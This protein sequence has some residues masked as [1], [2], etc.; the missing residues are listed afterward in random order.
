M[1]T[2]LLLMEDYRRTYTEAAREFRPRAA[3][4]YQ[5]LS[6]ALF[7]RGIFYGDAYLEAFREQGVGATQVVPTCVPL[8]RLWA[9]EHRLRFPPAVLSER[10]FRWAWTRRGK[11]TPLQTAL[12][13]IVEEQ[14][15]VTEPDVLWAF[16]GVP[17]RH[18]AIRRWRSHVRTSV[19]WWSCELVPDAAYGDFDLIVSSIGPLVDHFRQ[20]GLRAEHMPHAF[21]RRVLDRVRPSAQRIP[22]SVFVGNL[23]SD[24]AARIQFLDKLSRQVE[25]DFYGTGVEHLP[26]DSP[27]RRTAH[28]PVWGDD[29]YRVYGHY[30]AVIHKNIDVAGPSASAKRLFEAT[31]MGAVLITE[32]SPDLVRLF[33]PGTEVLTY[34]GDS[35]AASKVR[36][37]LSDQQ[38]ASQIGHAG[39]ART[40]RDHTY[41]ARVRQLR[42]L[43]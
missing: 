12:E 29:L 13:R 11:L 27:L 38:S 2:V 32:D 28:G 3:L 19:L 6:E 36:A 20:Q 40:L 22:R 35:E 33:E 30:S 17:L 39:Q 9:K 15:R 23:T 4:S 10:P 18:D 41:E 14:V 16:S 5:D 8:Q 26:A 24:H 25:M 37:V 7:A 31:G 1:N 34:R 21:D 43:T 42:A